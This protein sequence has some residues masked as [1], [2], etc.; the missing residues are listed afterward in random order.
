MANNDID[1]GHY[2]QKLESEM[3]DLVEEL[4]S[5]GR[6][7]PDNPDDWEAVG[8][9]LD[10]PHSA[11]LNEEADD[12][13]EYG[14]H[15]AILGTLEPRFWEVKHALKRI[16]NGTFGTCEVCEKTIEMDR[17]DA[18]AAARTCKEH[19]DREYRFSPRFRGN[20]S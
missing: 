3:N 19:M 11:D 7:N 12:I 4:Q 17:L 9:D 14:E 1:T 10:Q 5:V 2:K 15:V 13:E 18:N 20:D 8:A 16:E 6:I